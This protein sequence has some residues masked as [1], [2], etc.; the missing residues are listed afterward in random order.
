M[1]KSIIESLLFVTDEPLSTGKLAD[2][3]GRT[4]AEVKAAVAELKEDLTK[5]GRGIRLK[6]VAG[7]VRLYT[8]PKNRVYIEKLI[9]SSDFRRL[10]Q[11]GL[12]TLA[13]IAYRQPITRA[14]IA[15]I[16]G[17]SIDTVLAN[18]IAKGLVKETGRED[19]PGRP[20]LY[21]TTERFLES[22]GLDSLEELPELSEF[23]PDE[24]TQRKIRFKLAG[25]TSTADLTK[26][27]P[28]GAEDA[29]DDRETPA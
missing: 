9:L 29:A 15:G 21:G 2:L 26:D 24:E 14:E 25:Q 12:E 23:E 1:L 22:F 6:S 8:D 3:T 18:L 17:V 27:Q 4:E 11:A 28:T 10:T 16:R 7:G 19:V 5:A 20:T 13:I